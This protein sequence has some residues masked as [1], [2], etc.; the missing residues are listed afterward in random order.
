VQ[1]APRKLVFIQGMNSESR[2]PDGEHFLDRAPEWLAASF[3]TDAH[4]REA[5]VLDAGN[6]AYF[7]YSGE[8]CEGATGAGGGAPSYRWGDTCASIDNGSAASLKAL[9]DELSPSR[10]TVIGHSMG[11]LVAA[12][13]AVSEPEW[14]R[15]HIVSIVTFDS[16]LGGIDGFR[17]EVLALY[18]MR[19]DGCGRSSAAM[20]DL[21]AGS[22]VTR[23]AA[24]AA[25]V[26][27]FFT[28]DGD[29]KES[30]A[31]G[32]A[33]AVPNG[34][35]EIAGAMLHLRVDEEH[36]AIWS[37]APREGSGA[38]KAAFVT[39]ALLADARGCQVLQ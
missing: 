26:V 11:G 18:R 38:G 14:A 20:D 12:Y 29:S 25:R 8:Y 32:I 1:V 13:L 28:L 23:V 10:V 15:D 31:F 30:A 6:F 35:T 24:G 3:A 2:C 5:L 27:P 19:S 34:R 21:R 17:A 16:P 37:D 39:C 36:S 9:I 33:E 7:S 22:E 4:L